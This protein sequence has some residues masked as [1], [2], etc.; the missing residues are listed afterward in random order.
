MSSRQYNIVDQRF[1][2]LL[3][4]SI[5]RAHRVFHIRF[6]N[7]GVKALRR[8]WFD[9]TMSFL[10]VILSDGALLCACEVQ[11]I[12]LATDRVVE[13]YFGSPLVHS[14]TKSCWLVLFF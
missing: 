11:S 9:S 13:N 6:R 3:G 10:G 14:L 7:I 12:V 8:H 1:C 5:L 4:V 2:S